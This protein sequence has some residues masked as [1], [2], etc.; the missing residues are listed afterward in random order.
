M[1]NI[2]E[3]DFIMADFNGIPGLILFAF[4]SAKRYIADIQ[5][6]LFIHPFL[7]IYRG[8]GGSLFGGISSDRLQ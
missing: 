7:G 3:T 1:I 6:M 5:H 8:R 2:K 4:K